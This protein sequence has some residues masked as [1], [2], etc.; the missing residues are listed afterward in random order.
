MSTKVIT[1]EVTLSFPHFAEPTRAA[2]GKGDP[3]FS[4]AFI[5]DAG[6]NLDAEKAALMEAAVEQ[7]GDKAATMLKTGQITW[8]IRTDWEAKGYAE[9]S[10]FFNARSIT[11]PGLVYSHAD[12][13]T[14]KPALVIPGVVNPNYV[15]TDADKKLIER[16]FYAGARVRASVVAFAYEYR[17]D[18]SGPVM[19]RG[20]SFGLNNVQKLGDGPRLDGRKAAQ[21]EFEPTTELVP[22]NLDDLGV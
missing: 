7:W 15:L 17:E 20:V 10:A 16:V 4:A 6:A 19:K 18:A 8:P 12:P 2:N 13:A 3:K 5:Y 1:Q 22:A 9:G 14:K 21:D 11:Q